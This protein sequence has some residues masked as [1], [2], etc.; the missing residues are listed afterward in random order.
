MPTENIDSV[1]DKL[2]Q[3]K[4]RGV[5]ITSL[6]GEARKITLGDLSEWVSESDKYGPTARSMTLQDLFDAY[7][8]GT[9]MDGEPVVEVAPSAP[10]RGKQQQQLPKVKAHAK[11]KATKKVD[12]DDDGSVRRGGGSAEKGREVN[13]R[14]ATKKQEYRGSIMDLI[15]DRKGKSVSSSEIVKMS[16][17]SLNQVRIILLSLV[18]EEKVICTGKARA[19]RYFW[20]DQASASVLAEFERDQVDQKKTA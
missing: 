5:V 14:D 11:P 13:F 10:I 15:M 7:T 3:E 16:G 18:A 19:T 4:I 20:R 9:G 17:G 6:L 2:F 8:D 12:K 1:I